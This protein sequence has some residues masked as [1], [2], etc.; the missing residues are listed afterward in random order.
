M[1]ERV[2]K[3]PT[4]EQLSSLQRLGCMDAHMLDGSSG[5]CS[6]TVG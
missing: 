6:N 1:E 5:L 2:S 3:Q 4:A